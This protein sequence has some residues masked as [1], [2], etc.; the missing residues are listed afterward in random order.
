MNPK[1][2]RRTVWMQAGSPTYETHCSSVTLNRSLTSTVLSCFHCENWITNWNA[3]RCKAGNT[4]AWVGSEVVTI[5]GGKC[6]GQIT[7]GKHSKPKLKGKNKWL[8]KVWGALLFAVSELD[9]HSFPLQFYNSTVFVVSLAWNQD[10]SASELSW[11]THW[12]PLG[13]SLILCTT[14]EPFHKLL[15]PWHSLCI[16]Q[17]SQS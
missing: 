9:H 3:L 7:T 6:G 10:L 15:I 13:T 8:D 5:D 1:D 14:L 17:W 12:A 4:N 16:T 2:S 11:V